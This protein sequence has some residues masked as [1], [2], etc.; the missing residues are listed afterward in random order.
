MTLLL[1]NLLGPFEVT[2]SREPVT[3]FDS[4]KVR[5]LLSYLVVEA[6]R[7]HRR[8]ALAGLLWPERSERVAIRTLPH[9]LDPWNPR[10]PFLPTYWEKRH[11]PLTNNY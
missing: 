2:L 1:I 5:A 7:P 10:A 9:F 6:G 4:D 8:E 11:L 3:G